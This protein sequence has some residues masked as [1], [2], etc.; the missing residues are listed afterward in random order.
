MAYLL[1][2]GT[3]LSEIA[4]IG[5]MEEL[6][7][8]ATSPSFKHLIIGADKNKLSSFHPTSAPAQIVVLQ[9]S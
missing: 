5:R 7:N 2:L 3:R 1:L 8:R 4:H 6:D 9:F